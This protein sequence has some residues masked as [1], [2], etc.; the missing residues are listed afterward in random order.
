[1]EEQTRL[2]L[3]RWLLLR[4]TGV[5]G[6]QLSPFKESLGPEQTW[7]PCRGCRNISLQLHP[8]SFWGWSAYEASGV[9]SSVYV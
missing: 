8:P 1:M 2:L 4:D 6:D 9:S 5:L 7:R 3:A